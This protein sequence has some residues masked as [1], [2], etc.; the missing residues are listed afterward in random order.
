L[1]FAILAL[2]LVVMLAQPD[3]LLDEAHK[4]NP[5]L[6][7]QVITDAVLRTTVYVTAVVVMVWSVG[8]VAMGVL[9]WRRV[10]WAATGLIVSA[11]IAGGICLLVIVGS[12]LLLLPLVGCAATVALLLRPEAR[13]WYAGA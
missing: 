1:A 6:A 7:D 4:Q 3:A 5:D 8:A 10:R 9:A 11:G 2:T 12:F 13:R